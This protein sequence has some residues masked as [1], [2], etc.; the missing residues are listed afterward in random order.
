M[1]NKSMTK[2]EPD[3]EVLE[4]A[5]SREIEAN[6]FYLAL[7]ER[8]GDAA[9]KNVLE[10]LAAEELEHKAKLEMEF[11]KSGI[12]VDT[13]KKDVSFNVSDYVMSDEPVIDMDYQDVLSLCIQ[14]EDASFRLYIDLLP[15]T[16]DENA[17]ETLLTIIE[18]E[19]KHKVRFEIEYDNF[20]KSQG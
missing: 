10:E 12:V 19:I 17:K 16:I 3:N 8:V 5:I 7:A 14:K 18:E 11:M 2:V 1:W 20:L 13:S 4:Y 6:K 15:Y 9:I